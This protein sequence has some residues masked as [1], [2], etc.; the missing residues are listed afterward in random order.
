MLAAHEDAEERSLW[1]AIESLEEGADLAVELASDP[2]VAEK[3][4]RRGAD[5]KRKLA[6][7]I[8]KAAEASQL[9][10]DKAEDKA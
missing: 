3:A 10:Q 5:A 2:S 7:L 8:R 6:K 4:L 1:S 9:E